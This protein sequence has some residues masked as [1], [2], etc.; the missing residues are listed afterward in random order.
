[1]E[2]SSSTAASG[3][4]VTDPSIARVSAITVRVPVAIPTAMSTRA[5]DHRDYI[6]VTVTDSDGATGTGYTYA[7]TS[8]GS[9]VARAVNDLLAPHA[10]GQPARGIG[11]LY[12]RLA[13]EF[14]LVGRRGG[15]IRA[16][17]A[18]DIALWDLLGQTT[19]RSLR[20]LLGSARSSVPAYASGGYYRPGGPLENIPEGGASQRARGVAPSKSKGCRA[21]PEC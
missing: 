16:L 11:E 8:A 1:M 14:L 4:P 6:L 12:T 21:P 10:V 20:N 9:W 7:G 5:L 18:L 15:I 17:S 2:G 3:T 19:G 13:Q